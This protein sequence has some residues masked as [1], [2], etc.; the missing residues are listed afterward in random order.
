MDIDAVAGWYVLSSIAMSV[1]DV[2]PLG[3]G[4]TVERT[5]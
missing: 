1:L 4:P 3:W 5:P 2:P